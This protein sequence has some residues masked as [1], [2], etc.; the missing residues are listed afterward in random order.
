M[1]GVRVVAVRPDR[2]SVWGQFTVFVERRAEVQSRLQARGIPSAVHYPLP[3]NRQPAYAHLCCPDCCPRSEHAAARVLSLP[4]SA[5]LSEADQD[6]VVQAL[7]EAVS[8]P[9]A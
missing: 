9:V 5:D 3:L 7:A 2:E 1:P 8:V 6:R 4:M